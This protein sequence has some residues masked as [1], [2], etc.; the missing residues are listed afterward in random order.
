[1]L[2]LL[3]ATGNGANLGDVLL[4]AYE[5]MAAVVALAKNYGPELSGSYHTTCGSVVTARVGGS[6]GGWAATEGVGRDNSPR[7]QGD[8]IHT[9]VI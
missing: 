5:V 2:A 9:C 4:D 7:S 3:A 8:N 1:M 6:A